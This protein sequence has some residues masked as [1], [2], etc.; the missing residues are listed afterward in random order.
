MC[1]FPSQYSVRRSPKPFLYS[2]QLRSNFTEPSCRRWITVHP[3]PERQTS[4]QNPIWAFCRRC[5]SPHNIIKVF[6]NR[7]NTWQWNSISEES[8]IRPLPHTCPYDWLVRDRNHALPA[9]TG[10]K[11]S[12]LMPGYGLSWDL[13][14]WDPDNVKYL[15]VVKGMRMIKMAALWFR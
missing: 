2:F 6:S 8:A 5:V 9:Q 4:L 13:N 7:Y 14:M 1:R 11:L 15:K 3:P 12:F 10:E